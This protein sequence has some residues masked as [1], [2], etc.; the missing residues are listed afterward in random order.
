MEKGK[1][2]AVELLARAE[3]NGYIQEGVAGRKTAYQTKRDT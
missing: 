1:V 2:P 3:S